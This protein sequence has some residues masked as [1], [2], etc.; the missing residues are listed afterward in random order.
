VSDLRITVEGPAADVFRFFG[1]SRPSAHPP[2][3]AGVGAHPH[4]TDGGEWRNCEGTAVLA[5]RGCDE[6]RVCRITRRDAGDPT[7]WRCLPCSA[8]MIVP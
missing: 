4:P 8:G 7:D 2:A 5:C 3:A 6:L 1:L